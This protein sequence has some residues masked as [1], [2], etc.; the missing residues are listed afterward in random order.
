MALLESRIDV[1]RGEY[2]AALDRLSKRG[3]NS[4]ETYAL[5]A[6]AAKQ[7]GQ[8]AELQ[9]AMDGARELGVDLTAIGN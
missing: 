4:A 2:K 9:K 6:I 1:R 8:T 3:G 7:S 5:A